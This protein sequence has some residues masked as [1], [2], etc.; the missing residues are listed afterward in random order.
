[1][2]QFSKDFL[3]GTATAAHQRR[4]PGA[5]EKGA[6]KNPERQEKSV[7]LPGI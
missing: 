5:K 1:M 6:A 7:I 2:A 4:E 3:L